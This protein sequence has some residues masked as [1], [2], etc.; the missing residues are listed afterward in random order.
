MRYRLL[1]LALAIVGLSAQEAAARKLPRGV[2]RARSEGTRT[3]YDSNSA[4]PIFR[5]QQVDGRR[6]RFRIVSATGPTEIHALTVAG[7]RGKRGRLGRWAIK[8]TIVR[9]H[10]QTTTYATPLGTVTTVQDLEKHGPTTDPFVGLLRWSLTLRNG[11]SI[12]GG[13]L[14]LGDMW[15]RIHWPA[16]RRRP[17][18]P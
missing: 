18:A 16:D 14:S 6:L 13:E 10:E 2:R 5:V 12:G 1:I 15:R 11:T 17:Q 3:V 9:I 7:T 4:A 8:E